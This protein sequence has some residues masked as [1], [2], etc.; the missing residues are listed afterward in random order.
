[1]GRVRLA[2]E[3]GGRRGVGAWVMVGFEADP[4]DGSGE[5][6]LTW[7]Q[8]HIWDWICRRGSA[9]SMG[10]ARP[11]SADATVEEY[12]EELRFF[13]SR[14]QAMRTRLRPDDDGGWPRQVV[15]RS[16]TVALEIVDVPEGADPAEVAD[17]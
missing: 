9:L 15:A 17:E 4:P 2:G 13:M 6:P 5:A 11:A 1:M 10:A 7:G 8:Q 12:A 14:F 16:G 3:L